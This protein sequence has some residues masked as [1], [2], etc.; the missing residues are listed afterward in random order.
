MAATR[1][2]PAFTR[3]RTAADR[4]PASVARRAATPLR[5]SASRRIAA[6]AGRRLYVAPS[7]TGELVCLVSSSPDGEVGTAC[8]PPATFTERVGFAVLI[9]DSGPG[10]PPTSV[11]AAAN[12]R[13]RGLVLGFESTSR[14]LTP[15][16]DGGVAYTPAAAD[17]RLV[18]IASVD[19]SGKRIGIL[20]IPRD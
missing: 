12:A 3:A 4:I 14:R 19:A 13:V 9:R 16:A 11:L 8:N 1:A 6:R 5:L 15:N 2:L 10:T 17:G 18:S 20:R 7:L